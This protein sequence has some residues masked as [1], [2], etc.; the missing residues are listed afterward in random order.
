MNIFNNIRIGYKL[1]IL[2]AIMALGMLGIMLLALNIGRAQMMEDRVTS[3]RWIVETVVGITAKL[4]ARVTAGD[5]SKDE[6]ISQLSEIIAGMRYE[7]S[8]YIFAYDYNSVTLIHAGKPELVGQNHSNLKDPTGI[9][10]IRGMSELARTKGEGGFAYMWPK[11]GSVEPYAKY[12]YVKA[13]KPWNMYFGTGIYLDNFEA[14]YAAFRTNMLLA[15]LVVLIFAIAAAIFISRTVAGAMSRLSITTV[16]LANGD[17]H[18]EIGDQNR[19]DEVG[20]L[21]RAVQVFK[22]QAAETATLKDNSEHLLAESKALNEQQAKLRDEAEQAQ[23][24]REAERAEAAEQRSTE[25]AGLSGQFRTAIGDVS[26]SVEQL[27]K[28]LQNASDDLK[29]VVLSSRETSGSVQNAS[30]QASADVQAVTSAA[31][32]LTASIDEISRQLA[33]SSAQS[34]KVVKKIADVDQIVGS[35][36]KQAAQISD[37]TSLITD[38]AEQ[39]NLLALNATIESARAGEAGKGFAVVAHE[40]KALA[41]QTTS[42]ATDIKQQIDTIQHQTNDTVNNIRDMREMIQSNDEVTSSIAS[43]VEEQGAATQEIVQSIANAASGTSQVSYLMDDVRNSTQQTE[44]SSEYV[45]DIAEKLSVAAHDLDQNADQF[46]RHLE[47]N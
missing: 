41:T 18:T 20:D 32:E 31:E 33:N 22:E 1:Y 5:I 3:L 40:V 23:H 14:E 37:I 28:N 21:A 13:Y 15:V 9:Y 44:K 27:V 25:L 17:M 4:D 8:E 34:G 45:A 16:A 26:G 6:A 39:T 19:R 42:A 38:I 35:L 7:G 30:D 47:D 11:A 10:P 12:S 2:T 29:K 46:L 24:Q 43:A 36:A